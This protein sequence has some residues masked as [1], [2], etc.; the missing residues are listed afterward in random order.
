MHAQD[1][2]AG[3]ADQPVDDARQR[4]RR[5]TK[6]GGHQIKLR[7][8]DKAPIQGT[9]NDQN[10]CQPF[11]RLSHGEFSARGCGSERKKPLGT[12][13]S[14]TFTLLFR[15]AYEE[16]MAEAMFRKLFCRG[17]LLPF[18]TAEYYTF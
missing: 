11:Q 9:D 17:H 16:S 6:D 12:K 14:K 5:T 18:K 13:T 2:Q 1:C 3:N 10:H 15:S 8:T 4:R 7:E